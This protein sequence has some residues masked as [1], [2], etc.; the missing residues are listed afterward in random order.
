[1][2]SMTLEKSFKS[3]WNMFFYDFIKRNTT[4]L[5]SPRFSKTEWGKEYQDPTS[6][7]RVRLAFNNPFCS[8]LFKIRDKLVA[9]IPILGP[10]AV[11]VYPLLGL[12][13]IA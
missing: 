11:T 13:S 8:I 3:S 2:V 6:I 7:F 9:S 12:Y 10:N 4:S 1:M 5:D